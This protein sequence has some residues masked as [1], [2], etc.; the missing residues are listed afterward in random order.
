VSGQLVPEGELACDFEYT[1]DSHRAEAFGGEGNLDESIQTFLNGKS[2]LLSIV[3]LTKNGYDIIQKCLRGIANSIDFPY[4]VIIGDTGTTDERVLGLYEQLP[5]HYRVVMGLEYHFSKTNNLLAR[6]HARGDCLLFLNNDVFLKPGV[7]ESMMDYAR[8]YKVGAVGVRLMKPRGVIDHDGQVLFRDGNIGTPDHLNVNFPPEKVG[9]E[10]GVTDGVTAACM[11]TR[12]SVFERVGGFDE[13]YEDVYQD[14]DYC[15]KL[16]KMGFCSVTVRTGSCLHLGSATRGTTRRDDPKV[17]SD[18]NRFLKQWGGFHPREKPV[19]SFVTCCNKPSVYGGFMR[20]LPERAGW[21]VELLPVNNWDNRFSVT[22]ALNLGAKA[23]EGSYT[24]YCHQD[25]LLGP[26]W[27]E[28]VLN[29]IEKIPDPQSIGI[30]GFEGMQDGGTPWSC[31]NV[32]PEHPREVQTLDELCL[33]TPCKGLSFD[34]SFK[35][36]YYGA[37]ICMSA[38]ELGLR[39][40]LLGVPVRHLSGGSENILSDPEGFKAEAR[41]FREKWR[42]KDVWTTTTKFLSGGI[43]YMILREMLNE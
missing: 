9:S 3:I 21:E 35:F 25:I 26:V 1:D 17:S 28:R 38:L 42:H 23:V 16:T 12:R 20:S 43:Y 27:M 13:K 34:E 22:R 10:D 18:R 24:V 39:N 41:V 6:K 11:L 29:A 8:V 2:E 4:E 30:I 14:C 32:N 31:R 15:L 7:V 40:Y 33:I 37:D 19:F 5:S 36:H